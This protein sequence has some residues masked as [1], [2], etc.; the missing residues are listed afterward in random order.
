MRLIRKIKS[1][2]KKATFRMK[3][4]INLEIAFLMSMLIEMK[5]KILLTTLT[6]SMMKKMKVIIKTLSN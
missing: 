5:S 6:L 1:P 4:E 2:A 3:K